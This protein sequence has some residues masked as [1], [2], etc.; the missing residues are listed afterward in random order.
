VAAGSFITIT[1]STFMSNTA[2]I[3]GAIESGGEAEI[4]ESILSGNAATQGG[5]AIRMAGGE[6]EI[7][8]AT[9]AYNHSN[10][11]GG[12]ISCSAAMLSIRHSTISGTGPARRG[13]NSHGGRYL[14]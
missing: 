13:P 1:E 3:G 14:L 2:M 8:Y 4:H 7:A 5:G 10:T 12:G 6:M 9:V 11:T